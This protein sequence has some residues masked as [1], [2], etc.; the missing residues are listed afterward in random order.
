MAEAL[1]D[2]GNA[3][4][5]MYRVIYAK[6][7]QNVHLSLRLLH[8]TGSRPIWH[9]DTDGFWGTCRSHAAPP[10]Q[11]TSRSFSAD[12][13]WYSGDNWNG[14]ILAVIREQMRELLKDEVAKGEQASHEPSRPSVR[15]RSLAVYP[16]CGRGTVSSVRLSTSGR[17]SSPIPTFPPISS[18]SDIF[19]RPVAL[20]ARLIFP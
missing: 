6:F 10:D 11:A 1:K 9:V 18:V 3:L 2:R 5:L 19:W 4:E 7:E 13:H 17:H 14:K 16:Y 8:D 12:R 20:L 15:T